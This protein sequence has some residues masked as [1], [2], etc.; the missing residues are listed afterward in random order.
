VSSR[1]NILI[2]FLVHLKVSA[3]L[4]CSNFLLLMLLTPAEI[5]SPISMTLVP[6]LP[7]VSATP[8]APVE[9]FATGVVDT[10]GAPSK[11]P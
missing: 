8:A 1:V 2:I 3:V 7:P 11:L 6:N 10:G 5:L 9:K 4:Y